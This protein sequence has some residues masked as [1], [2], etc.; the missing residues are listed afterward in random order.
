MFLLVSTDRIG[1]QTTT[2]SNPNCSLHPTIPLQG[3]T[4]PQLGQEV[5]A[6]DLVPQVPLA[7]VQ[8]KL[9]VSRLQETLRK[10][11]VSDSIVLRPLLLI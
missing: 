6:G 2:P 11:P 8:R 3:E 5:L 4:V 1:S 7:R 9:G 10:V